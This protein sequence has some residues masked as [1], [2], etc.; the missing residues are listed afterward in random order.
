MNKTNFCIKH[1]YSKSYASNFEVNLENITESILR[2][3]VFLGSVTIMNSSSA[4]KLDWDW[5]PLFDFAASLVNIFESISQKEAAI[6]KF[7][8]TEAEIFLF[9]EREKNEIRIFT[10]FSDSHLI[11]TINEFEIEVFKFY[12]IILT[13]LLS[14]YS[15][16]EKRD[17][18]KKYLEYIH[19]TK[20]TQY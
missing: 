6:E 11:T 7:D 14:T 8:F 13:D 4:I 3:D 9:F 18:F 17:F 5:I 2:Y 19:R 15:G 20:P 1:S 10:S 12:K 16:L